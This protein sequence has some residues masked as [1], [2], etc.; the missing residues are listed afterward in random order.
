MPSDLAKQVLADLS[1]PFDPRDIKWKPQAIK[2]NR[3]MA[4]AYI[5]ARLVTSRLDEVLGID[6]WADDY[7]VLPDGSVQCFLS[8]R[9]DPTSDK[10]I[11][12]VDVGSMSEQP[13]EGDRLKAAFSDA[14]KRC[15]VKVG[16]AKYLYRIPAIWVDYDAQKKQFLSTPQLPKWAVPE[17]QPRGDGQVAGQQPRPHGD[18]K[19][20]GAPDNQ[21]GRP[22]RDDLYLGY[23]AQMNGISTMSEWEALAGSIRAQIESAPGLFTPDQVQNLRDAM[24]FCKPEAPPARHPVAAEES[25]DYPADTPY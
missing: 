12:R 8:I 5:D 11:K 22:N 6:G 17:A 24:R 4:V 18:G 2:G 25:A 10:W 1:R 23:L 14:L 9:I 7:Q 16:V 15:A 13:D 3:A 21:R 19:L 20:A